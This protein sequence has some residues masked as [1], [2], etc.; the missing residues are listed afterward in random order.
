VAVGD[1]LVE[2]ETEKIDLEVSAD[3]HST[4]RGRI[5]VQAG[6]VNEVQPFLTR[7]T[8]RYEFTVVPATVEDRTRLRIETVFETPRSSIVT[9]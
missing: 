6:R 5:L 7:E 3:R 4:F 9:P 2:L 8:V 1:A